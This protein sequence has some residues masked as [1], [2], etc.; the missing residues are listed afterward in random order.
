MLCRTEEGAGGAG[1]IDRWVGGIALDFVE[2]L[3]SSEI[4]R[5]WVPLMKNIQNP[6]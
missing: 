6:I 5:I 4:K 1:R 2:L 3:L